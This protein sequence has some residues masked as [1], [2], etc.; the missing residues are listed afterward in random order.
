VAFGPCLWNGYGQGE[1]PCTITAM[2]AGAIADALR[3]DDDARLSSVGVAR[4]ATR[5]RVVDGDDRPLPPGE[6]GE[7]VVAG[8]TVMAGY[9]DLPE[10]ARRRFAAAGSTRAISAASTSSGT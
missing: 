3:D 5:V 4:F 1:T 7:V 9:L 2:G 10:R 8:P 6:I